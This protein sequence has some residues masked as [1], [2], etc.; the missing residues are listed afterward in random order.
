[1]EQVAINWFAVLGSTLVGFGIGF[2]WYGPLFGKAWMVEVGLTEEDAKSV[3]MTKI[4]AYTFCFQFMMSY[5]LAMFIGNDQ[6]LVLG[7]LYGFL[8]GFG[9]IA[10]VIAVNGLY[11]QKSWKY[12][13]INGGF[14]IVVF[15]LM[16]L[17][18]GMFN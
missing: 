12:I 16:G 3:D 6:G 11:E 18:I 15:T 1:M 5:C 9:W 7:G 8:T 4:F 2:L 14:W 10:M 13:L 17:V